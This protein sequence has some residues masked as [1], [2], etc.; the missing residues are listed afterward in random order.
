MPRKTYRLP[1]VGLTE[2]GKVL[3]RMRLG[4]GVAIRQVSREFNVNVK[5]IRKYL[6]KFSPENVYTLSPEV[7]NRIKRHLVV[8]PPISITCV[9]YIKTLKK[10]PFPS[11]CI[12]QQ[13][14]ATP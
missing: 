7:K 8:L 2:S 14:G 5:H 10:V 4:Q 13:D 1:R 6:K 3:L 12:F 9:S 11:N